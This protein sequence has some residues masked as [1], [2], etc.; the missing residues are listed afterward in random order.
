MKCPVC[1]TD[2]PDYIFYCGKCGAELRGP[3]DREMPSGNED[4]GIETPE[5][6]PQIWQD[7]PAPKYNAAPGALEEALKALLPRIDDN[8]MNGHA[9]FVGRFRDVLGKPGTIL[10]FKVEQESIVLGIG[11][12]GRAYV[13]QGSPFGPNVVL[14]GPEESFLAMLKDGHFAGLPASISVSIADMTLRMPD[15]TDNVLRF[16]AER[17][18]RLLFQ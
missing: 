1:G 12:D 17:L 6:T 18:L 14:T 11:Q 3:P 8:I 4:D 2:N 15:M 9:R 7:Q 10:V 16:E 13:R 5:E